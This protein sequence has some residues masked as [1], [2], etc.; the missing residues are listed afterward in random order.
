MAH[1]AVRETFE[2]VGLRI[3]IDALAFVAEVP[4]DLGPRNPV[5]LFEVVLNHPLDLKPDQ[6]E[7]IRAEFVAPEAALARDL[8]PS[9]GA[10]LQACLTG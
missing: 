2:E 10:Y 9:V 6:R 7:I 1:A 8:A 5:H 4:G 3:N